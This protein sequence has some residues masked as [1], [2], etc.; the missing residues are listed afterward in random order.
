MT[1]MALQG[2]CRKQEGGWGRRCHFNSAL[3]RETEGSEETSHEDTWRNMPG[4]GSNLRKGPEAGVCLVRS[5]NGNEAKVAGV[6]WGR[7]GVWGA[8]YEVRE[9]G[10]R[11]Q[12]TEASSVR[13]R[14]A[15]FYLSKLG[16][17][18]RAWSW[19]VV[20]PDREY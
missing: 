4:R 13:A 3:G 18:G 16:S 11:G 5:R 20:W 6:G 10:R 19:S 15:A 12:M 8:R 2:E 1:V 14:T 17:H 9:V 7:G